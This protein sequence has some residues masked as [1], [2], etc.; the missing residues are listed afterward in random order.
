MKEFFV[1]S[2]EINNL[3]ITGVIDD[4]TAAQLEA[5]YSKVKESRISAKSN[6]SSLMFAIIGALLIGLGV[7]VFASINW[8]AFSTTTKTIISLLPLVISSG[9]AIWLIY[10]QVNSRNAKEI[11]AI[12]YAASVFTAVALISRIF[13][14]SGNYS[15]F[16]ICGLLILPMVY[17]LDYI[18]LIPIYIGTIMGSYYGMD[19]KSIGVQNFWFTVELLLI[20]PRIVMLVRKDISSRLSRFMGTICFIATFVYTLLLT[21]NVDG[22]N[23]IFDFIFL[24]PLL[25]LSLGIILQQCEKDFYSSL[26]KLSMGVL[27][28]ITYLNTFS[29]FSERFFARIS[30]SNAYAYTSRI[31]YTPNNIQ[32]IILGIVAFITIAISMLAI[33]KSRDKYFKISMSAF[34]LLFLTS[35]AG[36]IV[37]PMFVANATILTIGGMRIHSGINDGHFKN[38][39]SGMFLVCLIILTR[40]FDS[41]FALG[42]KAFMFILVGCAFLGIN[43]YVKRMRGK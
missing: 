7:I 33:Y 32:W 26:W 28:V 25:V 43:V 6:T 12:L 21:F 20:I 8:Y 23:Q 42:V 36:D 16:L 29:F 10:R 35:L 1:P 9:L 27:L 4:A 13:H 14:L 24:I 41:D 39:N 11:V 34:A 18:A 2:E 40:F 19:F 22:Y 31:S 38:M 15:Y 3:L 17:L 5:H 37:L 30:Y